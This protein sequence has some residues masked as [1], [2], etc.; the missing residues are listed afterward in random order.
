MF[1]FRFSGWNE[2]VLGAS[3]AVIGMASGF[4]RSCRTMLGDK[5]LGCLGQVAHPCQS[6]IIEVKHAKIK[7]AI[8][9]QI[10]ESSESSL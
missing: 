8:K 3:V 10:P 4:L 5:L 7:N 6:I 2:Q 1:G 9:V